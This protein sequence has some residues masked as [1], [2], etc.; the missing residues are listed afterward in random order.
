MNDTKFRETYGPWAIVAGASEGLGAAF[1]EECA[2]RSLNVV[3]VAR[4]G[5]KLD[6]L[7]K[8][9]TERFKTDFR[10]VILDLSDENAPSALDEQTSDIDVGL[11]IYNAALSLI[12]PFISFTEKQHRDT[13]STNCHAPALCSYLFGKRMKARGRGGI[14]L[15]SSIAGFQGSATIAHYA[16]TKA[17][18]IVLAEGLSRDFAPDNIDVLACCAGST[19]T[20]GYLRA[21]NSGKASLFV[22][23]P[24]SVARMALDSIHKRGI[25]IP[26]LFNNLGSFLLRRILPRTL[27]VSILSSATRSMSTPKEN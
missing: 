12:G 4:S 10:V 20:P 26:G 22:M 7:R 27:S 11:L 14:L 18:N 17:Y 5:D 6:V 25:F 19:A 15:M 1:A 21:S 2:Q 3:L 23:D 24:R 8:T 16:A 13:V 9:F